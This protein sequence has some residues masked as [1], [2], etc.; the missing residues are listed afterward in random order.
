VVKH[1]LLQCIAGSVYIGS[2]RAKPFAAIGACL[3]SVRSRAAT[4]GVRFV[5]KQYEHQSAGQQQ[6]NADPS[7]GSAVAG[8]PAGASDETGADECYECV[9]LPPLETP[10]YYQRS[11]SHNDVVAPL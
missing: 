9:D 4:R 1:V 3:A 2:N 5:R 7:T 10:A 8:G 6:L 11:G